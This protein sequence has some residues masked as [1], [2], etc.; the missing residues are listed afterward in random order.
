MVPP[1]SQNRKRA[2]VA[3]KV[4]HREVLRWMISTVEQSGTDKEIAV[5]AVSNPEFGHIFPGI[6]SKARATNRRKAAR[7]WNS[8]DEY[9]LKLTT[10][11]DKA[12]TVAVRRSRGSKSIACRRL[13]LKTM[14]G[15][16]RKR[17]PWVEYVHGYMI[18]EFE[19]LQYVGCK[20]STDILMKAAVQALQQEG[21]E[22]TEATLDNSTGQ[23]ISIHITQ[24]FI[25]R[26]MDRYDIVR[27]RQSGALMSSLSATNLIEKRIAYHLGKME[28]SFNS[29]GLDDTLV[30]NMDETHF[31]FDLDD[32]FTL[33]R[34]GTAKA[35]Y[36]EVVSG[37][38]GMTMALRMTGGVDAKLEAPFLVFRHGKRTY[39]IQGSPDNVPGVSYRTQPSGWMDSKTFNMWLR[40]HRAISA[41]PNGQQRVLFCDN[42]KGHTLSDETLASLVAINTLLRKLPPNAT[43]LCQPLD[44]FIIREIKAEW[45]KEWFKEKKLRTLAGDFANI[46]GKVNHPPRS[47]YMRLAVHC[48]NV[49]NAKRDEDLNISYARKAMIRCGLSKDVDGVW[50]KEQLFKN[51]RAIVDKHAANF[52]GVDPDNSSPGEETEDESEI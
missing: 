11:N 49:V 8:R 39:P 43:H 23:P 41:L 1:I 31:L 6:D 5:R 51:L 20:L 17:Q 2:L 48:V 44:S 37:T 30:E 47:W 4:Q 10:E 38:A 42:A 13:Y 24:D 45:R 15:R 9:Q 7:W 21:S 22:F 25:R 14:G 40:E 27:R 26:F 52:H 46:S 19:R 16:G 34:I 12:L 32:T 50:R 18:G 29:Q 36:M 28:H 35:N 33:A 3:T